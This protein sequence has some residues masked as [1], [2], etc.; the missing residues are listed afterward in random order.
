[1]ILHPARDLGAALGLGRQLFL[2]DNRFSAFLPQ[3][4][5]V[6]FERYTCK[7]DVKRTIHCYKIYK[8]FQSGAEI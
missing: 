3:I 6:A 5:K 1:M 7:G 8:Q 4:A 2:C